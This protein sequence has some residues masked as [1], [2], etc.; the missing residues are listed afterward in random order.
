MRKAILISGLIVA[1]LAYA[2]YIFVYPK[3]NKE[4]QPTVIRIGVLPDDNKESLRSRYTPLL[5]YLA[6]KIGH[7]TELVIPSSYG[8]LLNL[9]RDDKIQVAYFGGLTFVQANMFYAATP[10]VMRDVDARFTSWFLVRANDPAESLADVK[11]KKLTFGSRLSTSGHLMPRYFMNSESQINPETYFSEVTYSGAHDKTAEYVRDGLA[12]V[13]VANPEI[14]KAMFY[15]GRLKE[16]ELRILWETPP[17]VDYVWAVQGN[18]DENIQLQIRDAFLTLTKD[19]K[20]GKDILEDLGA[21]YFLPAGINDF[22]QL[23][24]IA[25]QLDMLEEEQ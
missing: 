12:D 3:L 7:D 16:K 1:I 14:I 23:Q 9:F 17:Y 13:G 6:Q 21:E 5:R 18:L 20:Q 22:M 2:T 19:D 15:D 8:E 4:N 24:S 10:L 11:N 25:Q